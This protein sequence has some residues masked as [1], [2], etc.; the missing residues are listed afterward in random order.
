MRSRLRMT[1]TRDGVGRG[2]GVVCGVS[3]RECVS[4]VVDGIVIKEGGGRRAWLV[5]VPRVRERCPGVF[6]LNTTSLEK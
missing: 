4:G 5:S 2:L 3:E 1:S 6:S